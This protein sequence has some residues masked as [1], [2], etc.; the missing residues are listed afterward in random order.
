MARY[1]ISI[2]LS[3]EQA[4]QLKRLAINPKEILEQLGR[5]I[6]EQ[7]K[8]AFEDKSF[9]G[10]SWLPQY[11]SESENFV[12][13][14]GCVADLQDGPIIQEKRFSRQPVGVDTGRLKE[15]LAYSRSARVVDKNLIITSSVPYAEKFGEGGS[16]VQEITPA[17]KANLK[18][19]L[20]SHHGH[21][22]VSKLRAL[23][24]KDQ[25]VTTSPARPFLG[26]TTEVTNKFWDWFQAKYLKK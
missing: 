22:A 15:S 2:Q 23:L 11:P 19:W 8:K 14:A 18:A 17:V 7:S 13:L 20:A 12:H 21:P 5:I 16:S 25:L 24:K 1:E 3:R 26:L 6:L 9:D 10:K 4:E